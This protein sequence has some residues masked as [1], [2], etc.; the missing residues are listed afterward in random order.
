[1]HISQDKDPS[2]LI[3]LG[4]VSGVFGV[5]GALKLFSSTSPREAIVGYNPL[6]LN[7]EGQ[8]RP[9]K[10]LGGQL[11]GPKVVVQLAGIEDRD[12][13]LELVGAQ[14]A[15]LRSQL[16]PLPADTHYWT[17]LMGL[18]VWNLDG[19]CLGV[20]HHLLETGANDV[21]V[22]KGERERLIPYI[23]QQVVLAVEM[24]NGILRVDWDAEF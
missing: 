10:V 13:A 18:E 23:R 2:R 20:V 8:W 3:L 24:E 7:L 15:V 21:L 19:V 9:F 14:V 17:D 16:P 22:V 6:R 1:M 11:Q 5:R 12:A 4:R